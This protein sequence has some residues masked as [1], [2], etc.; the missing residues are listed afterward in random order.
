MCGRIHSR[1][2]CTCR[3]RCKRSDTITRGLRND[4]WRDLIIHFANDCLCHATAPHV[5]GRS[6][7]RRARKRDNS[8]FVNSIWYRIR[9]LGQWSRSKLW[10]IDVV[11]CGGT[12]D[13]PHSTKGKIRCNVTTAGEREMFSV[14][15]QN[16][17]KQKGKGS[18]GIYSLSESY[19]II[20]FH[21]FWYWF[22]FFVSAI[23]CHLGIYLLL[24]L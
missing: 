9:W 18:Y 1:C 2:T 4:T 5:K 14:Y 3:T 15:I 11:H 23:F 21:R 8:H 6:H 20:K 10:K 24:I 7:W 12:L 19:E 16:N 17:V 22:K 13:V